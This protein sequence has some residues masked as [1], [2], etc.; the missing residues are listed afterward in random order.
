MYAGKLHVYMC[1]Y[2]IV[3]VLSECC[4]VHVCCVFVIETDRQLDMRDKQIDEDRYTDTY[5]DTER[6]RE[7]K[8]QRINER[9]TD[10]PIEA[11][12]ER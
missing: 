7:R 9:Q 11:E 3:F 1:V 12:I 6:D 4:H 10:R 5:R 2:T 8:I